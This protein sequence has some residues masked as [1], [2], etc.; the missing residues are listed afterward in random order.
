VEGRLK[1]D[2]VGE[3]ENTKYYTKVIT[4]SLQFLSD[5]RDR[6]KVIEQELPVEEEIEMS[7][8]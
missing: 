6:D 5:N 7:E 4:Q 3:G 2:R 8:S 1:T